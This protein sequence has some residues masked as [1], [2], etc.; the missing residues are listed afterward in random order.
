MD[1]QFTVCVK[2]ENRLKENNL[3]KYSLR[4]MMFH[5][6]LP[7]EFCDLTWVEEMVCAIYCCTV[8]MMHL[9]GSSDLSQPCLDRKNWGPVKR[10]C[11]RKLEMQQRRRH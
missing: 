7:E 3:P 2:C 4:N 9:Y 1:N 6:M 11:A 8:Q 10:L 5:G